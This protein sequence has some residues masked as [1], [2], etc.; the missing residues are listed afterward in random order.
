MSSL[1]FRYFIAF[2]SI[3]YV[4]LHL[5]LIPCWICLQCRK[6]EFGRSPGGGATLSSS[7]AWRLAWA[8][9]PGGL[10]SIGSQGVRHDWSHWA[11]TY[12]HLELSYGFAF[13]GEQ[14]ISLY[15]FPELTVHIEGKKVLISVYSLYSITASNHQILLFILGV[16]LFLP[17]IS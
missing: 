13:F 3:L 10:L 5:S 2:C 9:E 7:L 15:L 14:N 8:E 17:L 12:K 6:C 16:V 4:F 11:C 1:L